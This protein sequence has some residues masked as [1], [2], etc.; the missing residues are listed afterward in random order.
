VSRLPLVVHQGRLPIKIWTTYVEDGAMKQAINLSNLPF[1]YKHIALMPD[2][3]EG[4]GMPIG[5]VLAAEGMIIPNAVGVDIGCGVVAVKTDIT[6]IE[7]EEIR[8]IFKKTSDLIPVGFKHNKSPQEWEGFTD[9]TDIDIIH[10]EL[11]SAR[12][13]L[14]SLGSGNHF[15][16]IEHGSDGNIWL[17]VHSGSRNIGLKVA[18]YYNEL[19]K[20]LNKKSK[21]VPEEYNLA[22]IEMTS[23]EGQEYF[24]AMQFCLKFARANR[25][26]ILSRFYR[27]FAEVTG[28]QQIEQKIDI[29]HNYAA[30]ENHFDRMVVIHRK[31]A[32]S[33]NKGQF[34]I[35]PGSMGTSS[36]IVEGLGNP[37][38]FNSC[39]HGA[40]R[41]M[42]RK[43]ANKVI[44]RKKADESMQGIVFNDW[45]G[46]FSEAPPAYKDIEEVMSNQRD[47]VKPLVR[48]KPLGV[49]KG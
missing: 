23:E 38:S 30:I 35:I 40:G 31:G 33:A 5:G 4:Y 42:S 29:H 18:N 3:H 14:G 44:S 39:S 28:S 7:E 45:R 15:Y 26:L 13:Q 48:L 6:T 24:T 37:E 36:Y 21:I 11:D 49:M 47:L 12:H 1:A 17:M 16:S 20:T 32:T 41:V 8:K 10:Q 46:D 34:G 22:S 9:A 25:E 19:A 27:V 2:V 43:R